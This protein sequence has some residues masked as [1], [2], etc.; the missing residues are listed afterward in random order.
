[1]GKVPDDELTP[2]ERLLKA[3]FSKDLA[4]PANV[5]DVPLDTY[6]DQQAKELTEYDDDFAARLEDELDP[7]DFQLSLR[8][9]PCGSGKSSLHCRCIEERNSDTQ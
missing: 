7:L 5:V 4:E 8:S 9:C 3:I 6:I 2:E 1:M